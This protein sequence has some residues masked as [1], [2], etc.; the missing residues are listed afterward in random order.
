MKNIGGVLVMG[1][2]AMIGLVGCGGSDKPT[3][4]PTQAITVSMSGQPASL[5]VN[6]Q[7]SLTA[8]VA[9][10]S[11]SAGVKWSATCGSSTACGTFSASNTPSGTAVTYTAPAAVPSG[12]TVTV[13]ATS[14]T[15]GTKTATAT[16]TITPPAAIGVSI[17][18]QPSSLVANTTA[19]LT[20]TVTNDTANKG[21]TWT[22]SCGTSVCGFFNPAQTAS[23]TATSYLAPLTVPTGNTVT[24]TATSVTDTSKTATA[25]ITITAPPI[26]VSLAPPPPSP[27]TINTTTRITANVNNDSANGG[28]K[29]TVTCGGASCGSVATAQTA[30]GTATTY[31]APGGVPSGNTV[32]LTA[33]SVTDSTKSASATMTIVGPTAA[34]LNDGTYVYH[35]AGQ[36]GNGQCF[37]TGA[38]T[39]ANGVITGGEQDFTDTTTAYGNAITTAGSGISVASSGNL[40]IVLATTNTN[41]GNNGAIT[42]RGT[43]VSNARV[44]IS[45]Y[46]GYATGS[47][48]MD[49][50]TSTAAPSGGYAFVVNGI[51]L[52]NDQTQTPLSIGGILNV[53]GTSVSANGSV[54][55][56]NLGG[57]PNLGITLASGTVSA[58]DS[59]GRVSFNLTSSNNSSGAPQIPQFILTGY[60][61][62][63]NQIQL[64]ES[65]QDDLSDDLAGMALGQGSKTGAF[66]QSII[67]G[68]NYAFGTTGIDTNYSVVFAGVFNFS[69]TLTLSGPLAINDLANFGEDPIN[70]GSA[71]VDATGRVTITGVTTP[72]SPFSSAYGFQMYLDG[73][74]NAM[75]MGA[76][77]V[78]VSAGQAYLRTGTPQTAA[79]IYSMTHGGFLNDTNGTPWSASGATTVTSGSYTGFTDYA[80]GGTPTPNVSLTGSTNASTG[81]ISLAGLDA[82]AFTTANSFLDYSIDNNR[83]VMLSIDANLLDLMMME[84]V[85]K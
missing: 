34:A 68:Q 59:F 1:C 30:S 37:F 56:Y 84:T 63:T 72:N 83:I 75:L 82:V 32:T 25:T 43:K 51:D 73:N 58:P 74:G 5:T 2:L 46:D 26:S 71:T 69:P 38:F 67:A 21:V 40:Q 66:N 3:P 23:G 48:S 52:A 8:T 27:M 65:Q 12:N 19:A 10:D 79:G 62:G 55:D 53:S 81:V 24:V 14:V 16:I 80:D 13:T 64:I 54:F 36:N 31:T 6:A 76:D 9:N 70:G 77:Q 35:L 7:A 18:G 44:L 20:A 61:V 33:T 47:G 41:I 50:Q 49:L 60:I 17:S 78:E 39:V 42:L 57:S 28:V 29:W 22:V 85:T 4:P 11:A 45:E 15:D